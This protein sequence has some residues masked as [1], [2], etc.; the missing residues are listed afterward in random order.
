MSDE[1]SGASRRD[2]LRGSAIGVGALV[3]A[4]ALTNSQEVAADAATSTAHTYY[5]NMSGINPSTRIRVNSVSF[6]GDN[7]NGTPTPD[8][9]ALS[10]PS[11]QFSPKIL[12]AF[13]NK[14]TGI[15]ATIRGYQPDAV[16]KT[17]NFVTIT[18]A[19]SQITHYHLGASSGAPTDNVHLVF[20]SIKL[21]WVLNLKSFTWT[22]A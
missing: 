16:G 12:G 3:G 18:C 10:M 7:N 8:V 1:T 17:V 9:V 4:M 22:P 14:T 11:T 20:G 21:E 15:T 5:L 13:A 19:G 6:G 2:L